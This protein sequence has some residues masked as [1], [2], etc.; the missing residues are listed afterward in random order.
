MQHHRDPLR[1]ALDDIKTGRTP[2]PL[3]EKA[4]LYW[5]QPAEPISLEFFDFVQTIYGVE[6]PAAA[7]IVIMLLQSI[8]FACAHQLPPPG[9]PAPRLDSLVAVPDWEQRW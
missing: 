8:Y 3:I 1:R 6:L 9:T 5:L 2:S 7:V 4:K